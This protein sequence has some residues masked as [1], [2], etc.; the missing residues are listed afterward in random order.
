MLAMLGRKLRVQPT[1]S[2]DMRAS[3][4]SACASTSSSSGRASSSRLRMALEVV[5]RADE[6][7]AEVLRSGE[8]DTGLAALAAAEEMR[9]PK[10]RDALAWACV[11]HPA[12]DVRANAGA[13]LFY[14]ADLAE[15]SLAWD[16]RPIYLRLT[17]E[18]EAVRRK[19]FEQICGMVGMPPEL[20]DSVQ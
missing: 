9:S 14:F 4:D 17:N 5:P 19:A 7:V 2:G 15:D 13:T 20:A 10:I 6:T 8:P 18:D 3:L 12:A 16:Y 11:H 1:A